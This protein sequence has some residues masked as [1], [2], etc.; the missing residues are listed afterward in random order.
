[1][2]RGAWWATV[3]GIERSWTRLSDQ[4]THHHHAKLLEL[5]IDQGFRIQLTIIAII[6]IA[7][8]SFCPNLAY[9]INVNFSKM[10][11]C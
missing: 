9:I 1:M 2:D 4:H 3:H 11:H 6:H 8:L 7:S 5:K 10:T